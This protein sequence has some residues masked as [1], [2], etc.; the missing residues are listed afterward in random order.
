MTVAAQE[1]LL[2]SIYLPGDTGPS[3]WHFDAHELTYLSGP[4]NFAARDTTIGYVA[5]D[6]SWYFLA[7]LDVESATARCTLVAFGD[8]ITNGFAST[9]SAEDRWPDYLALR[10]EAE[11]G[12]TAF[13]VVDE[14]LDS[15][16]VLTDSLPAFGRSALQRFAHDALG[17]PG[18]R[19]VILLEGIN[20]I[21]YSRTPA[22]AVIAGYQ[23]LIAVAHT[24][25]LAI[26]GATLTPFQG[27]AY[28]SAAGEADRDAVNR[29]IRTSGAFDGV[30][31]FDQALRD[32]ADPLRL[33]PAYDSGDHLHPDDAGDQA[34]AD[35]VKLALFQP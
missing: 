8:S 29:W 14:G 15:N 32:P 1:N 34:M 31:D 24:A 2:I 7:G 17:Q 19:D 25:G 18:V 28:Y 12:G 4:G 5:A 20:D 35:A 10:L 26:F 6:S 33:R 21:G 11:P 3:T 16:R 27:S 22:A 30:I 23:H 13:G 9:T